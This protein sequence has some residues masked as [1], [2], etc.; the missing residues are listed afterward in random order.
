MQNFR[1]EGVKIEAP[2]V[3]GVGR[4][5]PLP[6]GEGFWG[7]CPSLEKCCIFASKSHV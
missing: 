6:S 5:V 4:G 7:G 3:W 1:M 2:R